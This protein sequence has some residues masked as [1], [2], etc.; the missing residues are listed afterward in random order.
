MTNRGSPV[1]FGNT[2]H[3]PIPQRNAKKIIE[4]LIYV[5][6]INR[7]TGLMKKIKSQ[8]EKLKST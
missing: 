6:I 1:K 4:T 7:E 3:G 8:K 5:Y 2:Y